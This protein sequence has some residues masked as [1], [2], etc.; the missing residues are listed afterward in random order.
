MVKNPQHEACKLIVS[1]CLSDTKGLNW[2][3]EIKM[4]KK[5]LVKFPDV[6]FWETVYVP[7]KP[8]SLAFFLTTDG[9]RVL[10]RAKQ[11]LSLEIVH[12]KDNT[13]GKEKQ[14]KDLEFKPTKNTLRDFLNYGQNQSGQQTS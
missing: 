5:L 2:A 12:S 9:E 8:T 3:K 6:S 1:K 7:N 13:L 14:G 10:T 11:E 4:A